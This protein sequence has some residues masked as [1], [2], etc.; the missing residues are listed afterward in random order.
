MREQTRN[1]ANDQTKREEK[2][3]RRDETRSERASEKRKGFGLNDGLNVETEGFVPARGAC[4]LG[5]ERDGNIG[6]L[7]EGW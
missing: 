1:Q 2:S 5:W 3:K 7:G 4:S 6:G